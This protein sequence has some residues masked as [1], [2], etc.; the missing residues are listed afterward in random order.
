MFALR[1]SLSL[2]FYLVVSFML[3][4]VFKQLVLSAV[5]KRADTAAMF[6]TV[7][8]LHNRFLSFI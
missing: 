2:G 7:H 8:T 5:G 4:E 3:S 6:S 1:F